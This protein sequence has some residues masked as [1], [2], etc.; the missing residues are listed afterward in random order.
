MCARESHENDTAVIETMYSAPSESF[1][2]KKKLVLYVTKELRSCE[3]R[4]A[5]QLHAFSCGPLCEVCPALKYCSCPVNTSTLALAI[6]YG[7][8]AIHNDNMGIGHTV[9]ESSVG[10]FLGQESLSA[11]DTVNLSA[12]RMQIGTIMGSTSKGNHGLF[13]HRHE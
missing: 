2:K 8:R 7:G 11:N 13:S 12:K 3:A 6:I 9:I 1:T 5:Q 10:S 4:E